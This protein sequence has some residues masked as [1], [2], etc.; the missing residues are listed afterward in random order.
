MEQRI[1]TNSFL[2]SPQQEQSRPH[3]NP[4]RLMLQQQAIKTRRHQRQERRQEQQQQPKPK[5]SSEFG[6]REYGIHPV[7]LELLKQAQSI[8]AKGRKTSPKK[9]NRGI[10][11]GPTDGKFH[12]HTFQAL[13][14][15]QRI[16]YVLIMTNS[17]T[18]NATDDIQL[19]LMTSQAHYDILK[20]CNKLIH[21]NN[22]LFPQNIQQWKIPK[23]TVPIFQEVCRLWDNGSLFDDVIVTN[24]DGLRPNDKH[25]DV[26][27]V[28]SSHWLKA[29]GGYRH[30]PYITS[31]FVDSDAFPCPG[32]EKLFAVTSSKR[33]KYWQ[34]PVF[35]PADLAMGLEQYTFDGN[36]P[37]W[38]PG[39]GQGPNGS[40]LLWDEYQ[41]FTCRN[42]GVVLFHFARALAW[43][44]A[45]FL[46]LVAEHVYNHV[47]T[48]K[49][50]VLN[51]QT[52]FKVAHF[53]FRRL[54][55]DFV[56]HQFP[57]HA[58]CRTYPGDPTGGTDGFLNGMFPVQPNGQHCKEC[59][60][61]PC[62]ITHTVRFF[63]PGYSSRLQL[64]C[65]PIFHCASH[66]SMRW[67]LD[68]TFF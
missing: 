30:A 21:N 23:R 50:K 46:P 55:P 64:C 19:A 45:E 67:V 44:F 36:N 66:G 39:R 57:M 15:A 35:L 10:V 20:T 17:S 9:P 14:N 28:S 27:Q 47:A 41:A 59:S 2:H 8:S 1:V 38:N 60:C 51:D 48:K 25:A 49:E 33:E 13:K 29:L 12:R 52:P 3:S 18:T 16:R 26:E 37:I 4:P 65:P 54:F 22:K 31:L 40:D 34:F 11:I 7:Y 6:G 42:T 24:L 63:R 43:E 53:I 61:T 68:A 5:R 32:L 56:E 58:S 62:L